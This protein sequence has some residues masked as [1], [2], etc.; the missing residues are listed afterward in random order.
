LKLIHASLKPGGRVAFW[1]AEPEPQFR[2]T[3]S[4]SGFDV[5]E[6]PAK[7]HERAKRYAHMIYVGQR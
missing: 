7:A 4:R 2:E 1:S 3:L 6:F 5:E